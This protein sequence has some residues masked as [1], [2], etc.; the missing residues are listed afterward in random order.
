MK[1]HIIV[2]IIIE[3]Q[4]STLSIARP[5]KS[6]SGS[7][8]F[9]VDALDERGAVQTFGV[10][11]TRALANATRE[12]AA[13]AGSNVAFDADAAARPS[14]TITRYANGDPIPP[15]TCSAKGTERGPAHSNVCTWWLREYPQCDCQ[16][17]SQ[18]PGPMHRRAGASDACPRFR[19]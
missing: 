14:E 17:N 2:P 9:E 6:Q 16:E 19:P 15:C 5:K 12:L 8:S 1:F 7:L 3:R 11:F 10:V 13:E 4:L 18:E